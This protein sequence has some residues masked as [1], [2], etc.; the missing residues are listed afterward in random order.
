MRTARCLIVAALMAAALPWL[1]G[2]AAAAD[3]VLERVLL[4]TGGVG[5]FGYRATVEADGRLRLTVPL[6]QVDDVLKSLTV[7]ADGGTVQA[8]SLL[9]PT[10]LADLFR[11]VPFGEAD[12]V[13]LPSLLLSLR[14]AEVEVRGASTLRGRILTVAREEA[15]EGERTTVTHRLS[16]SG[17]DGI[18]SV[19]LETIDGLTLTEPTLQRQVELVLTRL[20]D[21]R[22]EQQ[23]ELEI[24]LGG[25]PGSEVGLG[26]LAEM[27]LWKAS[28][29]LVTRPEDGLLQGWAILE[30]A[31]GQDWHDVDVTLI[32]GSPRAL[33]QALF[34]SHFVERP[35]VPVGEPARK[36]GRLDPPQLAMAPPALESM[37]TMDMAARA[38]APLAVG[39]PQELTAQTLFHLP[40]RVTLATGHTV[41]APIVDRTLPIERVA[42]YRAAEGGLHPNAALRLRNTAGA[43]LPAGLATLYEEL[44]G[45]GLTFLGDAP[46]PQLAPDADEFL[47]Y[48]L[49]GNIDVAVRT[50]VQGRLDRART[51]DGVLELARV[52][53]QSFAYT[54]TSRFLGAP[55]RFVLELPRPDGWRVVEPAD[56]VVEGDTLQVTRTL[57]PS[58]GLEVAVVLERPVVQRIE[59]LDADP[60]QLLLEFRGLTPPPELRDAL[61]QLQALSGRAADLEREI[62]QVTTRQDELA[63]EQ[64]RL[65]ENLG[66]VPQES[67]L[68]RR[69]LGRLGASEDELAELAGRLAALRADQERAAAERR[70]FIRSLQI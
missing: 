42:R 20:G 31:S 33:R 28:Y 41:M 15:T 53:Q 57:P 50:D 40:Q 69:Y 21:G 64:A 22:G 1:A 16:V 3:P 67:D 29:R 12:L 26:Y 70:A 7:L 2:R 62:G 58:A 51:A 5:Y 39:S 19:V 66:A 30:N 61:A 10:P 13:D 68:A 49:D 4:S 55:R 14:G 8:V 36:E 35:E 24:A 45:G 63:R 54:V 17:P 37:A 46:V 38:P 6:R 23:R 27:P 32:A 48:G 44:P 43:S 9:G 18:R 11:D 60:E 52:E 25:A 47:D 56:A 34:A 59:L 65:R